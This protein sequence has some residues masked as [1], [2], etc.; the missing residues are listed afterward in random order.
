[1]F[2][3][4][5]TTSFQ[6]YKDDKNLWQMIYQ[7]L[8]AYFEDDCADELTTDSVLTMVLAKRAF[9][10]EPTLS[11]F[12]NCMD[13]T[14]LK[15]FYNLMRRFCKVVYAIK[16]PEI[17]LLDLD[18]TLLDTYRNQKRED[19]NFHYQSHGYHPL[20][21]YDG[22]TGDL[23]KIQLRNGTD[24]SSTGVEDFLHLLLDEFQNDYPDIPLLLRGN[25]GFTK[26]DL[27]EQSE[28]NGVSY[29]IRL[30]ESCTGQAFL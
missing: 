17:L 24:Y 20:V 6:V 27:Y 9:A 3:T 26:P 12:F 29:V 4:N 23:L 16:K 19:F 18:S 22:I 10:S 5:D 14:T 25:S 21:Y 13:E 15:Q 7:I 30:K 1:M 8:G 28:I 2:K 11:R